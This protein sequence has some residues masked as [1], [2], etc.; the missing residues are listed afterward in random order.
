MSI[1][2]SI[3]RETTYQHDIV[4]KFKCHLVLSVRSL[5]M[6][7]LKTIFQ[8]L[9]ISG[10]SE[11]DK[12]RLFSAFNKPIEEAKKQAQEATKQAEEATK[13][14]EDSNGVGFLLDVGLPPLGMHNVSTTQVPNYGNHLPFDKKVVQIDCEIGIIEGFE[15]ATLPRIES[16]IWKAVVTSTGCLVDWSCEV[17]I[18]GYVQLVILDIIRLAGLENAIESHLE[19]ALDATEHLRPDLVI[20]RKKGGVIIGVCEVK[21]PSSSGNDLVKVDINLVNQ[22]SSYMLRLKQTHGLEAVF[23]IMTTYNEWRICWLRDAHGTAQS[24]TV[25][26]VRSDVPI[27]DEKEQLFITKVYDRDDPN[28]V[29][30]LVSTV[31][32]MNLSPINPPTVLLRSNRS[33]NRKY[34]CF[35]LDDKNNTSIFKWESLPLKEAFVYK[36]PRQN[37][38]YF[39]LVQDYHGGA[40]GR[41]WL[42][43]NGGGCVCVLKLSTTSKFDHEAK[44]WCE[45]WEQR[46]FC[47]KILNSEALVLPFAFHCHL[48]GDKVIFRGLTSWTSTD[49]D[50]SIKNILHSEVDCEFV[51]DVVRKYCQNPDLA[52]REALHAMAEK[53]WVH[54]DLKWEHVALLPAE[55]VPPSKLWTVRP[56]LIDLQRIMPRGDRLVKEVVNDGMLKLTGM[57][58]KSSES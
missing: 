8:S 14:Y 44:A 21:K 54:G 33:E 27:D 10:V 52:A 58:E 43:V 16:L 34:G 24:N 7:D 35:K 46:A 53:G 30:A 47:R 42:S 38:K 4:T 2:M 22:L 19:V 1:V 49:L 23:G 13:K 48:V 31:R 36:L 5:T 20:F 55:P 51:E 28:L 50:S 3:S 40:D 56:V 45:L 6:D 25:D 9:D 32:K 29:E 11:E 12:E 41:V 26:F 15:L 57:R 39:Y 17:N 18:Q 37:T